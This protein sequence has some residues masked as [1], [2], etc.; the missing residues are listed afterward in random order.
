MDQAL[1][2]TIISIAAGAYGLVLKSMWDTIKSLDTQVGDLQV[3]V[4]GEYLKREEWKDDMRRLME[5]LDSID[6]KLDKK[7]DK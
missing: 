6:E 5:K 1:I 7:A 3:S 4:A 2:N